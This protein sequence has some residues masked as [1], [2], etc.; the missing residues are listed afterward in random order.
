[1]GRPAAAWAL[2]LGVSLALGCGVGTSQTTGSLRPHDIVR[3]PRRWDGQR[4][5]VDVYETI[6]ADS[7]EAAGRGEIHVLLPGQRAL[8]LRLAESVTVPETGGRAQAWIRGTVVRQGRSAVVIVDDAGAAPLPEPIVV[9]S[10]ATVRRRRRHYD[11][12]FVVLE[13]IERSRF[14]WSD[15]DGFWLESHLRVEFSEDSTRDCVDVAQ[16]ESG[17]ASPLRVTG[18][19][20]TRGRHGH[21][22]AYRQ[23][24]VAHQVVELTR[25]GLR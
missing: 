19:V 3:H 18:F 4:V 21:L 23:S 12:Q 7:A 13:G 24:I 11:G 22:G 9:V 2:G 5:T 17:T 16:P 15:F 6:G 1:M 20:Y 14:E 10:A 25:C 8:A